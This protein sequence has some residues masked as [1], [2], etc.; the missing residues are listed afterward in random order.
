MKV[1]SR[2]VKTTFCQINELSDATPPFS[3]VPVHFPRVAEKSCQ[4]A[5]VFIPENPVFSAFRVP[6]PETKYFVF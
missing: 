1:I 4:S 2:E 5:R 3:R 6:I